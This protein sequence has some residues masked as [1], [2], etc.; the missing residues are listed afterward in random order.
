M[1]TDEYLKTCN[2]VPTLPPG[3]VW[4]ITTYKKDRKSVS[5][6]GTMNTWVDIHIEIIDRE[7]VIQGRTTVPLMQKTIIAYPD[8]I[9]RKLADGFRNAYNT[10]YSSEKVNYYKAVGIVPP[11]T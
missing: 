1:T 5:N 10:L 8:I 4:E 6:P 11:R 7:G 2:D 3:W 9:D